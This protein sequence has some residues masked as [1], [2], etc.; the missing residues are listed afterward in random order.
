[1]PK[2]DPFRGP[3][4]LR[5]QLVHRSQRDPLIHDSE[6]SQ[7]ILKPI[8]GKQGKQ[9]ST[10]DASEFTSGNGPRPDRSTLGEAVKYGIYFDDSEYDYMKHLRAVGEESEG[11][12]SVLIEVPTRS[13]RKEKAM[14]LKDPSTA[15]GG[16]IP[17]EFL[18][19]KVELPKDYET[20]RNIPSSI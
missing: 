20:Q 10:I 5:F 13:K 15:D 1:M 9:P 4:A 18:P 14:T 8:P 2:K 12:D 6:A 17:S 7:N 19:P 16:D 3:G 11:V